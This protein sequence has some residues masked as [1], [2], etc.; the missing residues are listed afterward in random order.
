MSGG[1]AFV[2]MMWATD[3]GEGDNPAD[4]GWLDRTLVRAILVK[5]EVRPG[6]MVIVH[7]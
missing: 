4:A 1:E 2:V 3:L 6:S 7:I 5:G